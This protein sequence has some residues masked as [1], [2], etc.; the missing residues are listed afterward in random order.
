MPIGRRCATMAA[1]IIRAEVTPAE[2]T[3]ETCKQMTFAV[4]LRA[5]DKVGITIPQVALDKAQRVIR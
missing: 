1:K 3:P 4:N 2:I 5:A